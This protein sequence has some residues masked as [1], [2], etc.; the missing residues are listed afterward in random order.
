[1]LVTDPQRRIS[2]SDA[3]KD[4]WFTKFKNMNPESE[5]NKLDP[6]LLQKLKEFRGTSK[7]KKVALNILVKM[8]ADSKDLERIREMF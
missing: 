1:M 4:V 5:E 3:L 2:A 7:L 8:T 6:D